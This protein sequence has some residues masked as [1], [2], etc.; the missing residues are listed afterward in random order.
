MNILISCQLHRYFSSRY[1]TI[2]RKIDCVTLKG[3]L[4]ALSLYTIDLCIDNLPPSKNKEDIP[5]EELCEINRMKKYGFLD[6]LENDVFLMEDVLDNDKSIKMLLKNFNIEFHEVF[7]KGLELYLEG[8]WQEAKV[9]LESALI[10]KPNDGPC[11]TIMKFMESNAFEKP[12][13]WKGFRELV[14]K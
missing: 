12:E 9:K 2:C 5:K 8:K 14:E 4:E 10:L 7:K 13:N 11:K 3:S 6:G 1:Q